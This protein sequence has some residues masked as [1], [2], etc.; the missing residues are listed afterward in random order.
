MAEWLKN[1]KIISLIILIAVFI[2][3][4]YASYHFISAFFGALIVFVISKPFYTWL[5][6]KKF[7]KS[8]AA[9]IIIIL[10]L[11]IIIIPLF[12]V[13]QGIVQQ[14]TV[15]PQTVRNLDTFIDTIDQYLP[16]NL[17]IDRDQIIQKIVPTV[18]NLLNPI[19]ANGVTI[20]ANVILFYFLLYYL[21]I[22]DDKFVRKLKGVMPF[23]ETNKTKVVNKF[24]DITKSTIIGSLLIALI[25]GGML[26]IGFYALG[27]HGALFWGFVTA[28]L[29]FVPVIGSPV[30]WGP[31]VI[32]FLVEGTITKAVILLI[33]GFLI[34]L[35]DNFIRPYTNKKY[36]AIHPLISVFGVFI[37]IAQFG[38][39]GIFIGPL[40]VAYFLLFW[41]I[42][43]EEY[44]DLK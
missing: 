11:L 6:K 10:T 16:F 18:E 17:S 24:K 9:S 35:V 13:V 40:L 1:K 36:G 29:S 3:L 19:L 34:T 15:L 22:N 20:L 42:Y 8:V 12:F 5:V 38:F 26:A 41:E 2:F 39:M 14:V 31:A 33:W 23:T 43:K 27:I 25:Q 28:L 44:L 32:F 30:I 37:G 4:A 7:K 21:L